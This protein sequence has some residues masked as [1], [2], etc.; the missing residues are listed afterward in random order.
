[1]ATFL[2][3]PDAVMDFS[4]DWSNWLLAGDE[5]TASEWFVDAG[6]TK[7]ADTNDETSTTVWLAGGTEGVNYT[8]TNRITTAAGRVDDRVV[9]IR[10]RERIA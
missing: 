8:A 3:D 10:C 9:E 7:Q 4:I 5:I 1:M 2:K 6:L